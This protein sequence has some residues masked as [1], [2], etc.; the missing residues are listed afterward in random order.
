MVTMYHGKK[1]SVRLIACLKFTHTCM[2]NKEV[3]LHLVCVSEESTGFSYNKGRKN[4]ILYVKILIAWTDSL[5]YRRLSG[6]ML[7]EYL[8]SVSTVP[9]CC[10]LSSLIVPWCCLD[11]V[12]VKGNVLNFHLFFSEHITVYTL[13]Q[14]YSWN[15]RNK[16]DDNPL[17]RKIMKNKFSFVILMT[18]ALCCRTFVGELCATSLTYSG[19]LIL[20][21]VLMNAVIGVLSG[22][23][24]R[25]L[26]TVNSSAA[27][28][29]VKH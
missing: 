29:Q 3:K 16:H 6:I 8:I 18:S 5:K 20:S 15:M 12:C 26:S 23:S 22:I 1:Q 7:L 13:L 25:F 11:S 27:I 17:Y 19:H 4:R 21:T 9:F 10:F 28:M 24:L 14:W 2:A